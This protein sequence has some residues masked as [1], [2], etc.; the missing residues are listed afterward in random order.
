MPGV[1]AYMD[2][3]DVPGP[4]SFYPPNFYP[5]SKTNVPEELF[6][7]GTV[8]YFYQPVGLIL[9]VSEEIAEKAAASV[10]ITY[11]AGPRPYLTIRDILSCN[12]KERI[13]HE[14]DHPATRK[15]TVFSSI[16]VFQS[17]CQLS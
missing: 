2:K 16:A 10:K 14:T 4:N 13:F 5:Y 8:Q 9:A 12:A 3:N 7:S 17:F 11:N 1:F 6:C 15:G